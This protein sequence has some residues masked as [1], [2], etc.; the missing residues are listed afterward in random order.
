MKKSIIYL[1][2][3]CIFA[4]VAKA[5]IISYNKDKLDEGLIEF[6]NKITQMGLAPDHGLVV[7]TQK[8]I[9]NHSLLIEEPKYL[10]FFGGVRG[11]LTSSKD[12]EWFILFALWPFEKV[13]DHDVFGVKSFS[14][15]RKFI[16]KYYKKIISGEELSDENLINFHQSV[17]QLSA[18]PFVQY[19]DHEFMALLNSVFCSKKVS[20]AFSQSEAFNFNPDVVH[21]KADVQ[22]SLLSIHFYKP[23]LAWDYFMPQ[24][25][26]ILYNI[27]LSIDSN[28]NAPEVLSAIFNEPLEVTRE[29]ELSLVELDEFKEA[30]SYFN[31]NFGI[32]S[33]VGTIDIQCYNELSEVFFES[34]RLSIGKNGPLDSA[35]IINTMQNLDA[36]YKSIS[37]RI[38]NDISS[39]SPTS[40]LFKMMRSK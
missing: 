4:I 16:D 9:T 36:Y 19:I 40:L 32:I 29:I 28:G 35:E 24:Y 23:E 12:D 8:I 1:V 13:A 39:Y 3:L 21:S 33:S 5:G 34:F 25:E 10:D 27:A 17:R 26:R 22:S 18:P 7:Y 2:V 15:R 20:S 6:K 31:T 30:S 37:N 11:Y 14:S 38:D